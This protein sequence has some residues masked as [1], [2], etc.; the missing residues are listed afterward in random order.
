MRMEPRVGRPV[1]G[2]GR[3]CA[4]CGV[5]AF[6]LRRSWILGGATLLALSLIALVDRW[7]IGGHG[8]PLLMAAFGA[9]SILLYGA[10]QSEMA[11]PW[12]IFVGG[13]GSACIG[14]AVTSLHPWLPL[15]LIEALAVALA[16]VYMGWSGSMHPPAGAIALLGASGEYGPLGFGFVL[17]PVAT[18]LLIMFLVAVVAHRLQPEGRYPRGA[19]SGNVQQ[20]KNL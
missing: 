2:F 19:T 1:G 20:R 8:V 6:S 16:I 13:I 12:N 4:G 11:R 3:S 18:G 7:L 10:P 5:N 9:S 14:V 15:W 17:C